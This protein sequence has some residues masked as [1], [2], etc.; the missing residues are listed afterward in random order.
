[1]MILF[2]I[3]LGAIT[4]SA[5]CYVYL[6]LH[7]QGKLSKASWFTALCAILCGAFTLAWTVASIAEGEMQAAAMGVMIFGATTIILGLIT[8]KIISSTKAPTGKTITN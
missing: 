4:A 7:V 6:K 8:R 5:G 1:M 2:W 3:L